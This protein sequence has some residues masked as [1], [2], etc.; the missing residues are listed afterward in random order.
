[1]GRGTPHSCRMESYLPAPGGSFRNS[2]PPQGSARCCCWLP[3]RFLS[4][5]FRRELALLARALAECGLCAHASPPPAF[6]NKVLLELSHA[7]S[8]TP[9]AARWP[10]QHSLGLSNPF[11]PPEVFQGPF[12]SRDCSKASPAWPGANVASLLGSSRRRGDGLSPPRRRSADCMQLWVLCWEPRHLDST[13]VL[14]ASGVAGGDIIPHRRF[15]ISL[16]K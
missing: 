3:V 4:R 14:A 11:F 1:M 12:Q 10:R 6:V 9:V 2:A 8:L 5:A 7:H 15:G 13:N 16:W